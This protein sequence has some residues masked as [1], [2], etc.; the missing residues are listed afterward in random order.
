MTV[1]IEISESMHRKLAE[2]A[3][4]LFSIPE[5]I[6]RLMAAEKTT[7]RATSAIDESVS[8]ASSHASPSMAKRSVENRA[9]RERGTT[10]LLDGARINAVSVSELYKK[11]L[12]QMVASGKIKKLDQHIPFATS[13][14]RYLIARKPVHPNGNDF[15]VKVEF[16]GYFMEAHKSYATAIQHLEKFSGLGGVGFEYVR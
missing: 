5:V 15:F 2:L 6:E 7:K 1:S 16:G 11:F 14:H 12:A 3:G 9:P 13:S 8:N 4:P 10:I